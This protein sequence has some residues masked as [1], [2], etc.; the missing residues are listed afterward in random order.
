MLNF[1]GIGSAFNT[2]LGNNSAYIKTGS[3]LLLLDCGSTV[4]NKLQKYD[5]L[6]GIVN[7]YAVI[8]H[9]HPDHIGSLGE[10]IFYSHYVLDC[11]PKILFPDKDLLKNILSGMG[12]REDFYE[13]INTLEAHVNDSFIDVNV[14]FI[15][16]SHVDTI[17]S[18]SIMLV[19]PGTVI[20]YSGDSNSIKSLILDK[21]HNSEIDCLYQD[22][23]GLDYAGNPHFYLGKLAET[24]KPE[25]RHKVYCMHIDQNFNKEEA[26][27][28]GFNVVE[29]KFL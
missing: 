6:K 17:P 4:F 1:L 20:F 2:I 9:T 23:C 27:K 29:A 15:T 11:K 7:L 22:T 19:F 25:F 8:T 3:T 28:L 16:A 18:Y 21:L 14:T 12:V 5:I 24:V 26:I 10:L 13:I